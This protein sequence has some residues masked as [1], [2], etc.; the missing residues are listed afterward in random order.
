MS[1]LLRSPLFVRFGRTVAVL[2]LAVWIVGTLLTAYRLDFILF[3]RFGALGNAVAVLFF[4]DRLLR[5][6]LSRQSSVERILHEFGTELAA[7][8]QGT[9]ATELPP[10]GYSV[11]Y[12]TE[13]RNFDALRQKADLFNFA[14]TALIT[15]ATL[16]WGFGDHVLR[17]IVTGSGA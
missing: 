1:R 13:E 6:E 2:G 5:I 11:D 16:Q 4:S 12:L 3:Q 14:N 8:K 7:L 10:E 17:W 15:L 9:P